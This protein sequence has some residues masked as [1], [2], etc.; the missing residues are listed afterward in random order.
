[1]DFIEKSK[2]ARGALKETKD[3]AI[4]SSYLRGAQDTLSSILHGRDKNSTIN[5]IFK[6][7]CIGK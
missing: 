1:L 2:E 6:G 7:F 4:A 5:K 3:L